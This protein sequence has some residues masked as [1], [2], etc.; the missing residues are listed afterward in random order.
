VGSSDAG[1]TTGIGLA[2]GAMIDSAAV[3]VEEFEVAC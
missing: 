3:V 2:T 1:F